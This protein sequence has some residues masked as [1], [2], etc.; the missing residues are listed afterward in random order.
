MTA[1]EEAT[2]LGTESGKS[3][4]SWFFDGNT[5]EATYRKVLKQLDEGDPEVYGSYLMPNL[6]NSDYGE[7]DLARDL[8]IK[9]HGRLFPKC[10]WAYEEAQYEAFW[11]EVERAARAHLEG[12]DDDE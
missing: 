2:R 10:A 3:A 1:L 9:R 4:A 12:D 6:L 8:G 5:P 11:A 7:A